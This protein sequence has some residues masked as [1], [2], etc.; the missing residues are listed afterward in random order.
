[1]P[2]H[3]GTRTKV[4]TRPA[5]VP[6]TYPF[7]GLSTGNRPSSPA[8]FLSRTASPI[9]LPQPHLW[10]SLR[11]EFR[12]TSTNATTVTPILIMFV[13]LWLACDIQSR[14]VEGLGLY[15]SGASPGEHFASWIGLVWDL[16]RILQG[17][18]LHLQF[19]AMNNVLT[20]S[21]YSIL[22][23]F[24][25]LW[26]FYI[27]S[28]IL[29]L[30]P[31]TSS[32]ITFCIIYKEVGHLQRRRRRGCLASHYHPHTCTCMHP[33]SHAC[34]HACTNTR[35]HACMHTHTEGLCWTVITNMLQSI[36]EAG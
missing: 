9:L 33:C 22:F 20:I 29:S 31:L 30:H 26:Y 13:S 28:F 27:I 17:F 4:A 25:D 3:Q 24:I 21:F 12:D 34:M 11:P 35:M 2:Q 7:T 36:A 19:T 6:L 23:H 5:P 1:M 14:V 32:M 18:F 10:P 15:R 16:K 8:P